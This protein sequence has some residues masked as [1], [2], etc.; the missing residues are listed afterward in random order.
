MS[1]IFECHPLQFLLQT[2]FVSLHLKG[3]FNNAVGNE[4]GINF[5]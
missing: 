4:N 5:S 3:I 1:T 2:E